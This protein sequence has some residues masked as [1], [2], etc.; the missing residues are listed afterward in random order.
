MDSSLLRK[1]EY[2]TSTGIL[3]MLSPCPYSVLAHSFILSTHI[4]YV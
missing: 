1:L 3:E 2:G 4:Y